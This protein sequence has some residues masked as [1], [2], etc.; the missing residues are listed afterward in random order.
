MLFTICE[1]CSLF[2]FTFIWIVQNYLQLLLCVG[3]LIIAIRLY[4]ISDIDLTT[5]QRVQNQLAHLMTIHPPFTHSIPQPRSLHWFLVRF[6]IMFNINLLTYKTL[7]E[8]QPVYLHSMLAPSRPSRSLRSNKV[9]SLSVCRVKTNTDARAFHRVLRLFG[10]TSY[11]LSIQPFQ[12]LPSKSISGHISLTWPFPHRHQHA[13][14]PVDVTEL[15]LR[16]CC[17]TLTQLSRHWAWLHRGYWRCRN[18][19]DWSFLTQGWHGKL[20]Y[21]YM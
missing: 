6:R 3:I 1:I 14:W 20:S 12:L 11:C 17:W 9:N 18:L 16:F 19:I 21:S 10:I 13:R 8:K 15:F 7:R 5:L 2:A 4:G